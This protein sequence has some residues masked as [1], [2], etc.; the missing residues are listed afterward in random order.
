MSLV[1]I[2]LSAYIYFTYCVRIIMYYIHLQ[3]QLA[4]INRKNLR[5]FP[6]VPIL[7]LAVD[8]EMFYEK[9]SLIS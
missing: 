4:Q 2:V 5:T 3:R 8:M 6:A 7:F 9:L 1:K